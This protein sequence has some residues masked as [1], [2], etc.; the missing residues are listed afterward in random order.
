MGKVLPDPTL[1]G[2]G[3]ARY[4]WLCVDPCSGQG[5]CSGLGR[6]PGGPRD[7]CHTGLERSS[8]RKDSGAGQGLCALA[9][10]FGL[11]PVLRGGDGHQHVF[12]RRA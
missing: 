4:L 1:G 10:V 6:E 2:G 9:C 3:N 7:S 5:S 11:G 8:H 12:E